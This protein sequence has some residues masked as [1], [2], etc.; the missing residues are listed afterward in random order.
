M[1]ASATLRRPGGMGVPG[2]AIAMIGLSSM[3][4]M[5]SSTANFTSTLPGLG[6][7]DMT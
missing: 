7:R 3:I 5:P 6:T 1:I 4:A 2:C